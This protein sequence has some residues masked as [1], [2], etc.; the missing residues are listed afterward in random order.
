MPFVWQ[1]AWKHF[2]FY[3]VIFH[4]INSLFSRCVSISPLDLPRLRIKFMTNML[5]YLT[6]IKY[7]Q[8]TTS[9][10]SGST[11]KEPACQCRRHKRCRFDPWVGKIPWRRAQ[12]TPVFLSGESMGRG[13]WRATVHGVTKS[14]TWLK[15]LSTHTAQCTIFHAK[16]W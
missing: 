16:C 7:L 3:L 12:P 6:F 8:C 1:D 10:P 4:I 13:A 2:H 5:M 9:L 14:Q 15:G 11:G